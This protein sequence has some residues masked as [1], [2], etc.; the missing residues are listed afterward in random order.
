MTTPTAV[1]D[2]VAACALHHYEHDLPGG[3]GKPRL[4]HEWTVYAAFVA[5]HN[6][7]GTCRVVS[8]ATGTKCT[9]IRRKDG[10]EGCIIHD[11]HAEVLARRGLL[12]VLWSEITELTNQKQEECTCQENNKIFE[13]KKLLVKT[14]SATFTTN[15]DSNKNNTAIKTKFKLDANIQLHLY[16]SDSPCGDASIYEVT[17]RLKDDV[18]AD[19]DAIQENPT[20]KDNSKKKNATTTIQDVLFTGAKVIVSKVTGVDA[21]DCGG[22]H[23][24]LS[25]GGSESN[26]ATGEV[27]PHPDHQV[28]V[29]REQQQALGKI[30]T[31]AG[32]S[33]LPDHL[34]STSM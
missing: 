14:T 1:A 17:K 11:S 30:R 29:A 23:Q 16:I 24:L 25:L 5:R 6:V 22:N 20:K 12:R 9:A 32:R 33:N 13:G 27:S 15:D 19:D 2:Q 18:D 31:K 3:R 10:A 21:T 7:K 34:R 28:S 8:S 4:H 26:H